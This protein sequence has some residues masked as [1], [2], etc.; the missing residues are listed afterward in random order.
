[1][2]A[3]LLIIGLL[4]SV[5]TFINLLY[6]KN[7]I[8]SSIVGITAYFFEHAVVSHVLF[9]IDIYTPF[10]NII[11]TTV[12]SGAILLCLVLTSKISFKIK[13]NLNVKDM[14]IPLAIALI[15]LPFICVKNG[16]YGMG[17]DQGVYQSQV[18][19]FVDGD[20]KKIKDFSEY[21]ELNDNDKTNYIL[22]LNGLLG[23]DS[24]KSE[25]L[26]GYY[27]NEASDSK[28]YLHGIPEFSA[29]MTTWAIAWGIQHMMGVQSFFYV[30]LLL[31]TYLCA[32]NL[33]IKKYACYLAEFA[34]GFSPL[35]IWLGKAAL[36][37]LFLSVLVITFVYLLTEKNDICK[38]LSIIPVA[39]FATYHPTFYVYT[40]VFIGIYGM[41]FLL[42]NKKYYIPL[43]MS[44][45]AILVYGYISM[46]IIQPVYTIKNFMFLNIIGSTLS[47]TKLIP[48]L[49]L[50]LSIAIFILVVT[51]I[52]IT[53]KL[54]K[55]PTISSLSSSKGFL[56]TLRLLV[57]LPLAK[58]AFN[59]LKDRNQSIGGIKS[60]LYQV[61]ITTIFHFA[62]SAA[63]ILFI[64]AIIRI[65][66]KPEL[67]VKNIPV[68]TISIFFFYTILVYT[69]TLRTYTETLFYWGRY[70]VPYISVTVLFVLYICNDLHKYFVAGSFIAC[71]CI[72]IPANI[73]MAKSVDDTKMDWKTL[74]EISEM[75]SE[76]D[77][78]VLT[79]DSM[80]VMW[81]P[82][83][84]LTDAKSVYPQMEDIA[85]Q[86]DNLLATHDNAFIVSFHPL[87]Y[88]NDQ[89]TLVYTT[90]VINIP[91][92]PADYIQFEL[93]PTTF[94]EEQQTVYVYKINHTGIDTESP[95][96]M[97]YS[98][99]EYYSSY[100]GMS[101]YEGFFAWTGSPSVELNC[102]LE[103]KTYEMSV[104]MYLQ[105]PIEAI[106]I[107]SLDVDVL[108]NGEY[109]DS[110]SITED[111]NLDSYV[112]TIDESLLNDGQNTITLNGEVWSAT[113]L[114]PED[115]RNLGYP[116]AGIT[117]SEIS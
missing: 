27:S 89:V 84:Y 55:R 59:I 115:N 60:L 81:M 28:V 62:M 110:F 25:V 105:I 44:I 100:S 17:Q 87:I 6:K 72:N 117:F 22:H 34:V 9:L 91:E 71:M 77:A 101:G 82:M 109:V 12:L 64:V 47:S 111:N 23:A 83:R 107:D 73:N 66:I 53:A 31:L 76:N 2:V 97:N 98:I 54:R 42:T 52:L 11:C 8:E 116:L 3:T 21:Y 114:N 102:Y 79:D 70:L 41:L 49:V 32:R 40:P 35:I 108:V 69:S 38:I 1:M 51:F 4:I 88:D 18:M 10:L 75:V 5:F 96:S 58:I 26:D 7:I 92:Y 103:K 45:P 80:L 61:K 93:Y 37:E 43:M 48:I 19:A 86:A 39:I 33:E 112:F 15:L 13:P 50:A 46:F 56:I 104:D 67:L 99:T 106:G 29:F 113:V 24:I 16:Y 78:I 85:T 36:T 65:L 30:L 95:E 20:T 90:S 63:I 74:N 94:N 14:I 68:L 57:V